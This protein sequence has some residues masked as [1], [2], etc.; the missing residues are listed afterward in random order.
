MASHVLDLDLQLLL[1][2]LFGSFEGKMLQKVGH[3]IVLGSLVSG[4]SINPN[5]DGGG[6]TAYHGLG[7]NP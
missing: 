7:S 1:G 5:T 6:L 3:S 4:S 2:A